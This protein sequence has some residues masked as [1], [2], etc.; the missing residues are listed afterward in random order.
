M[1]ESETKLEKG[2]GQGQPVPESEKTFSGKYLGVKDVL[3]VQWL[4]EALEDLKQA[5]EEDRYG[6]SI[7]KISQVQ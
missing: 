1:V 2:Q 6:D 5:R 3:A 4:N 7:R